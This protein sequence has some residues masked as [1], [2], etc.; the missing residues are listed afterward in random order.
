MR[1]APP[2]SSR[3]EVTD[4][5]KLVILYH[6]D[7]F[8]TGIAHLLEGFGYSVIGV[9]G[10]REEAIAEVRAMRPRLVLVEDDDRDAVFTARL[11]EL[12]ADTPEIGVI[13][14]PI[15]SNCIGVYSARQ[16]TAGRTEDLV[17]AIKL[18]LG[19]FEEAAPQPEEQPA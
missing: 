11:G 1:L 19:C 5:D 6:H 17:N 14:L 18:L 12:W 4:L 9:D 13:R 10:R 16:L 2:S 3:S 7:L 8:A 15:Q